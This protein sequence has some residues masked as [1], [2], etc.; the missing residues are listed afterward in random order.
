VHELEGRKCVSK[1][2]Q[3]KRSRISGGPNDDLREQLERAARYATGDGVQ[4]DEQKATQIY[5]AVVRD[6]SGT[7]A[8]NLATMYARGEGVKASWPKAETL[9][10][11][12]EK[13]GSGDASIALGEL[14]LR[15]K[16][17]T[18]GLRPKHCVIL[19]WPQRI[20]ICVVC[21]A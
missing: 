18:A 5:A 15:D 14:A 19:P 6:G 16:R 9:Y 21:C 12:A 10:R 2:R 4:K 17:V 1:K 8:F 20:T 13:L 11:R 3:V 7:A